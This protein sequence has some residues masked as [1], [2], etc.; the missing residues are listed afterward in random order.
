M[1]KTCAACGLEMD[2]TQADEDFALAERDREFPNM[3][4]EEFVVI[5]HNCWLIAEQLAAEG[6]LPVTPASHQKK[7]H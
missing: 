7:R 1:K 5:C 4:P 2:G 6:K 3:K